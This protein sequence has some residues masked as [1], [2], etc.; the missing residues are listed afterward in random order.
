MS[1]LALGL[2]VPI[3]TYPC[4]A[5]L[6]PSIVTRETPFVKMS[7]SL[8]LSV[9]ISKSSLGFTLKNPIR[10]LPVS[11]IFIPASVLSFLAIC[12]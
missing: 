2:V 5:P 6:S 8:V 7:T 9:P 10:L 1:N 12:I 11:D 3:P 4:V